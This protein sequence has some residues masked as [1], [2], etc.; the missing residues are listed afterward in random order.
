[1]N[2]TFSQT[3]KNLSSVK[4]N[5]D[6]IGLL[7]KRLQYNLTYKNTNQWLENL[8]IETEAAISRLPIQDQEG[9]IQISRK[10]K[11]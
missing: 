7:S 4:F 5:T 9:F 10:T 8:I 6:E 3:V 2:I 11:Y 1:M